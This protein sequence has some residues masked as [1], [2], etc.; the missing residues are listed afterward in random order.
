MKYTL[1]FIVPVYL[2]IL[3]NCRVHDSFLFFSKSLRKFIN[4]SMTRFLF[5]TYS[6]RLH[7]EVVCNLLLTYVSGRCCLLHYLWC[8][9]CHQYAKD[10]P[11]LECI[12]K[13]CE[14][15]SN[16]VLYFYTDVM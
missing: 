6:D 2:Y 3:H 16:L 9:K 13:S 14:F 11:G 5:S 4:A 7:Q 1:L 15:F 12:D 10:D 8:L